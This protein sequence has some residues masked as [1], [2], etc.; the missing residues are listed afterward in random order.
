MGGGERAGERQNS[1]EGRGGREKSWAGWWLEGSGKGKE[2]K[3][4]PDHLA[5]AIPELFDCATRTAWPLF[6]TPVC[7]RQQWVAAPAQDSTV[8]FA[9]EG[10][11]EQEGRR[12]AVEFGA[13]RTKVGSLARQWKRARSSE[14]KAGRRGWPKLDPGRC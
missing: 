4:K 6:A 5:E 1:A 8:R 2:R 9:P 12:A 3:G 14:R 10:G 13:G 11:S 7:K